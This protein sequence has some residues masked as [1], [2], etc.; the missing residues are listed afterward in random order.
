MAICAGLG[1]GAW[2]G[3]TRPPGARAS[4]RRVAPAND[5]LEFVSVAGEGVDL[6]V[7]GPTGARTTTTGS[8]GEGRIPGSETSVDC[9]GFADPG[10]R[11][12]DCTASVT[13]STPAPGD[14]TIVV[15]SAKVRGLTLN[16]GWSTVSQLKHGGFDVRAQVAAGGATAFTIAVARASVT[17]R[18]EPKPVSP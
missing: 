4:A 6:E 10:G 17:Q 13:I 5:S 15:R 11:E 12:M 16:V 7:T 2:K 18:S 14:Y 1:Y 9:P 3:L 8:V